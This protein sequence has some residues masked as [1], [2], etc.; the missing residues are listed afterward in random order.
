MATLNP[1]EQ[2]AR[3]SFIKGFLLAFLIGI[4]GTGAFGMLYFQQ[5]GKEK[6]RLDAQ[7]TVLV[8]NKNVVSGEIITE[9]M[10][11]PKKCDADIIPAGATDSYATLSGYFAKDVNGNRILTELAK[12]TDGTTEQVKVIQIASEN[13]KKYELKIDENGAYYYT[14]AAKQNITVLLGETTLVAKIDLGTNTVITPGMITESD[15]QPSK[16]LRDEQYNMI[17]LPSD[18]ADDETVDI[19]LRLPTGQDY[20]VLAKKKVKLPLIGGIPS[21]TTVQLK[22]TEDEI[23]T[24]SAAI[25]DAYQITGCKLYAV[26]YSEPGIQEKAEATYI[27]ARTTLELI[28][29][30]P[31]ILATARTALINFYNNN[32]DLYRKGVADAIGQVEENTRQSNIQGSTASESQNQKSERQTYL[33]S[34]E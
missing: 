21:S 18:L 5:T 7:K 29:K 33:Q 11:I 32:N 31:N 19:R 25:V 4:I 22:V 2:K 17:V 28:D 15:E 20:L 6:E 8:L 24:M 30:D 3:S 1:L 26:R 14:N 23:L 34:L 27:P 13:N 10:F 16:D 9:D 12:N